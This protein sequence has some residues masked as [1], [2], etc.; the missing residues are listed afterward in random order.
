LRRNILLALVAALALAVG[1]NM[2]TASATA[3]GGDAQAA[4]KKKAGKKKAAKCPAKPKKG[5]KKAGKSLADSAAKK[6][7]KKKAAKCKAKPKKKAKAKPKAKTTPKAGA[8]KLADGNYRHDSV[9][10]IVTDGG[11]KATVSFPLSCFAYSSQTVPL[12]N[13][14]STATASETYDKPVAGLA[15]TI[16]WSLTV[17]PTLRYM[18]KATWRIGDNGGCESQK[19]FSGQLVKVG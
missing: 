18:L 1:V 5:K 2:A 15:S 6:K 7:G 14:G 11:T 10:V 8:F 16:S 13:S 4:A 19:T 3:I 9:G 12:T 17:Q